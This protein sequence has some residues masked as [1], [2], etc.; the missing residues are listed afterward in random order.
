MRYKARNAGRARQGEITVQD[1]YQQ[2]IA[3]AID[4]AQSTLLEVSSANRCWDSSSTMTVH[5]AEP[6]ITTC[7]MMYA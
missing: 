1:Q 4:H 5:D 2:Q 7:V 3:A 6:P